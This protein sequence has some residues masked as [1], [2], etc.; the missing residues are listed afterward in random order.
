VLPRVKGPLRDWA[1]NARAHSG[2]G[3]FLISSEQRVGTVRYVDVRVKGRALVIA[4][5][6]ENNA[7]HIN[8]IRQVAAC[9]DLME[10]G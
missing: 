4:S 7:V 3:A 6:W 1:V 8:A 10:Q 5:P 9:C 2:E